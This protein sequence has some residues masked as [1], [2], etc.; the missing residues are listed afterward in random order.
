MRKIINRYILKEIAFPFFMTLFVFTFILLMG[1]ILQL[2]D[3]MVNKGVSFIDI[4]KLVLFLMPPFL[5][6]TI[7]V[8]FLISILIGLGRLS[9]DNEITIFKASGISLYQLVSPIA[10]ASLIT[11][12]MTAFIAFFLVP[13]SNSATRDLLFNIAKQKA[14]IGIKEK[15]FNDDFRGLVLYADRIPVHGNFMEGV[16]VSDNRLGKEVNTIIARKGY[17]V[18]EPESLT[19]TLRLENG[20]THTVD[21]NLRN[22]KKMDF[23]TYDI[24]LDLRTAISKEKKKT[25]ESKEMTVW[26]L[27]DKIKSRDLKKSAIREL[28]IELNKKLSIPLS[29]I[30]FGILGIPLGIRESRSGKSRG[31]VVG[32][33]VVL[34][35]YMLL[36]CGEALGETGKLS[37]IIG[38]WAPNLIFGAAGVYIFIRA[39]KEK[40]LTFDVYYNM[41]LKKLAVKWADWRS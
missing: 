36:L 32:L 33:L 39:T 10:F 28:V 40:P 9:G 14:S 29:C 26:E 31:F 24:N 11:F 12:I 23:S 30:V 38:V 7:P 16:L 8:A 13:H 15:I 1:K 18:S 6:F 34:I 17:L 25:K 37:P 5:V 35:Y 4:S 21:K 22:Y 20:S 27:V 3:L 2:M 19:V 41:L